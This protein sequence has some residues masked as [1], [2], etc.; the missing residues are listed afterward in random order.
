MML[1]DQSLFFLARDHLESD[2]GVAGKEQALSYSGRQE[3]MFF[4]AGQEECF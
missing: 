4:P 3:E 1:L 2:V